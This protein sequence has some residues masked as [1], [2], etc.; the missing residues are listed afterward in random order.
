M[1]AREVIIR[2]DADNVSMEKKKIG[3]NCLKWIMLKDVR[4]FEI[5]LSSL[6]RYSYGPYSIIFLLFVISDMLIDGNCHDKVN[7]TCTVKQGI[8]IQG[9]KVETRYNH[10]QHLSPKQ[11]QSDENRVDSFILNH[12]PFNYSL[13]RAVLN[14]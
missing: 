2:T 8:T 3:W 4:E 11:S 10:I 5:D 1:N 12:Y 7:F 9:N 14:L 13:E 6:I